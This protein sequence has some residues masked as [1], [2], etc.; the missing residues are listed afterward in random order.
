MAEYAHPESLVST[1][2]VAGHHADPNVCIVEVDVDTNAYH[3]ATSRRLWLELEHAAFGHG[4]AG[5]PHPE[6]FRTA[7]VRD[8]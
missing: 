7:D 4:A 2:W 8:G 5:Y 6:A 1:D 3:E